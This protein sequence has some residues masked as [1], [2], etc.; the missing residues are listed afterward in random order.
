MGETLEEKW[1]CKAGTQLAQSE[2]ISAFASK[3]DDNDEMIWGDAPANARLLFVLVPQPGKSYR[4]AK[5]VTTAATSA[6]HAHFRHPRSALLGYLRPD[7]SIVRIAPIDPPP[8][9]P[10]A[11][12]ELF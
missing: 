7:G 4:L 8:P 9:P 5:M 10:P 2:I 12:R 1:L 6:Q 11:Q 3:A